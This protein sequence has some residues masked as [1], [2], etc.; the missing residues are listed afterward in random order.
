MRALAEAWHS[1]LSKLVLSC[2]DGDGYLDLD[3]PHITIDTNAVLTEEEVDVL[4]QMR[5][6]LRAQSDGEER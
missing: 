2:I 5:D 3:H 1:I 6:H 4:R